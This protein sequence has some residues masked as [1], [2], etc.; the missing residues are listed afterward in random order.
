MTHQIKV[1]NKNDFEIID[2]FDGIAFNFQPNKP[3]NVPYEAACH[4]FG[5]D[6]PADAEMCQ[7]SEFR[8]KVFHSLQKRWGWNSVDE[9][10]VEK[11]K[12]LF[13]NLFFVPIVF[14][15]VESTA[16]AE[17]EIP[18]PRAPKSKGKM[19]PQEESGEEVA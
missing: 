4:I 13:S 6:F 18:E 5:V 9:K 2:Y 19:R 1:T 8:N 10:K 14:T 12:K 11:S 17:D 16:K 7:T 15:L 3:I